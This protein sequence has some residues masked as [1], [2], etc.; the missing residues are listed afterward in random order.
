MEWSAERSIFSVQVRAT[1]EI[2]FSPFTSSSG[3][4]GQSGACGN[5]SP[6]GPGIDFGSQRMGI[7][8][9]PG[10][11]AIDDGG[12]RGVGGDRLAF[13]IYSNPGSGT[14]DGGI[15][16][17]RRAKKDFCAADFFNMTDVEESRVL[18]GSD[19]FLDEFGIDVANVR[20]SGRN[21]AGQGDDEAQEGGS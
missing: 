15:V 17:L 6:G 7:G 8:I 10:C 9:L 13:V 20:W 16:F 21:G 11:A 5:D 18:G 12:F 2:S 19:G 3:I 14:I 1:R 4:G